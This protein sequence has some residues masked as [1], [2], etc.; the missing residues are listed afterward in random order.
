MPF[1]TTLPLLSGLVVGCGPYLWLKEEV[2]LVIRLEEQYLIIRN[3]LPVHHY[4]DQF[5]VILYDPF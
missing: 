1:V 2:I 4:S 3:L 5:L